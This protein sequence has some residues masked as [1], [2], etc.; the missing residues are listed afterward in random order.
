M[1]LI[2]LVKHLKSVKESEKFTNTQLS[3][4][5][6]DLIDMYMIEKVDLDS[7]IVFFDAEKT[8]NKLIVEIEGV[9]YENL[10][11]LNM[12]QDMVEEFVTTK[13]SASDLEIAE[14]L[15]NYRAKDA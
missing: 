13:A 1:K 5:E 10:F 12:A 15:I 6:Y 14:F 3:D 11:P 7:D 9:T 4:I 2:E 8:P